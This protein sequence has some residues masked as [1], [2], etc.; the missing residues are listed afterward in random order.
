MP[1]DFVGSNLFWQSG[2]KYARNQHQGSITVIRDFTINLEIFDLLD[3]AS[4][5]LIGSQFG[6]YYGANPLNTLT[7]IFQVDDNPSPQAALVDFTNG[8]VLDLDGGPVL[9][10]VFDNSLG[11]ADI[12]F[13]LAVPGFPVP[14]FTQAVLN[15]G[16]ADLAAEYPFLSSPFSFL[17]GFALPTGGVTVPLHLSIVA[18]LVPSP[19][20]LPGAAGL[21]LLGIAGLAL[22]RRK[23]AA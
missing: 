15:P 8:V 4:S 3:I 5:G 21:W 22:F 13:Y 20:P 23:V 1:R 19:I 6:F 17:I 11:N 12:G 9:E 2:Q 7:P 16:G 14:I 18:P 10:A